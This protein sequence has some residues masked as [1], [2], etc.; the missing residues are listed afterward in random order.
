MKCNNGIWT[1]NVKLNLLAFKI[2]VSQDL[3]LIVVLI[4]K[5]SAGS[6]GI[7]KC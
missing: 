4:A 1:T 3:F 6:K 7:L 5:Q 2:N